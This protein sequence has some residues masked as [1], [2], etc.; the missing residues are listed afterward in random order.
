MF[1][2][3][4][5]SPI[6]V[7][8]LNYYGEMTT[9]LERYKFNQAEGKR[10]QEAFR[11]AILDNNKGTPPAEDGSQ[12]TGADANESNANLA[13]EDQPHP[14]KRTRKYSNADAASIISVRD[15]CCVARLAS[16]CR[17]RHADKT[18]LLCLT[19]TQLYLLFPL[20]VRS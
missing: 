4:P 12:G 17:F 18:R 15:S 1:P 9:S 5:K 6:R 19:R 8:H 3:L 20:L 10:D 13:P 2:R 7:P 11:A 16:F 14:V